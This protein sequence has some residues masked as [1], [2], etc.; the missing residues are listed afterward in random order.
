ME[1]SEK[2]NRGPPS[3]KSNDS[4]EHERFHN[5]RKSLKSMGGKKF[6]ENASKTNE[7]LLPSLKNKFL[8]SDYFI[9]SFTG[10]TL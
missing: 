4:V 6:V 2:S 9:I 7:K 8:V 10:Q 1:I 5:K 3:I